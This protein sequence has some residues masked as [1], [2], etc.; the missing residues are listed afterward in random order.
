MKHINTDQTE[1]QLCVV[2]STYNSEKEGIEDCID[3]ALLVTPHVIVI[4]MESSDK[5][6]E[7]VHSKGIPLLTHPHV[8][9]VEPVRNFSIEQAPK[10][11][12]FLLDAD[13]RITPELAEEIKKAVTSNK[14]TFYKVPRKD[15]FARKAW[16]QHGGWWPNEII[17]L[18]HRPHFKEWPS[19]I[20]ST[21]RIEGEMGHLHN[22][23]LHYSKNDYAEIVNKTIRFEDIESDLLFKADKPV[24]TLTFFRKF[25]GELYR[26]MFKWKGYQDGTIGIIESIYQAFSKT[27]TYLYLYEKKNSRSV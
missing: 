2:I 26:R 24:N 11:W 21:P 6:A 10:D 16:L 18:I 7:I 14:Y 13:E 19:A 22:P 20:H 12:V 1:L 15:F 17:R 9:Y 8:D 5:T 25:L 27:I 4:D 23:L 3:S